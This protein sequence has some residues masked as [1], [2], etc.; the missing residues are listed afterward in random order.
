ML[1]T[2]QTSPLFEALNR[3]EQR[4]S[5]KITTMS[6]T[7]CLQAALSISESVT[8]TAKTVGRLPT[9]EEL[10]AALRFV[11]SATSGSDRRLVAAYAA[12]I[13][14]IPID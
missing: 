7:E 10:R 3:E 13:L 14:E 8:E 4:H 9:W 6:R 12:I 2:P 5:K 1:N 11:M